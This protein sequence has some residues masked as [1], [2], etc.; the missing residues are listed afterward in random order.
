MSLN[1]I[2]DS[3]ELYFLH[4]IVFFHKELMFIIGE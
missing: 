1:T 4:K 3:I 2:K